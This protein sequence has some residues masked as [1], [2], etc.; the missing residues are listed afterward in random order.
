MIWFPYTGSI[1][2]ALYWPSGMTSAGF[3]VATV[4]T[5][6]RLLTLVLAASRT[7]TVSEPSIPAPFL[8]AQEVKKAAA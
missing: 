8:E 5:V 7:R 1:P 3:A 2:I 6:V 4:F